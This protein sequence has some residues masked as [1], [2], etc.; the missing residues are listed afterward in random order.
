MDANTDIEAEVDH[1][2]LIAQGFL[3][4][5]KQL[6]IILLQDSVI[7]RHEFPTHPLW[8]DPIF[9]R[10]D[11][12]VFAK[13]VEFSLLEVEEPEEVWIRKTLPAIAEQLNILHQGFSHD[14]NE[15]G[16]KTKEQLDSI[17]AKLGDL[18]EGHISMT[19]SST[20]IAT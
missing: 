3:W 9:E 19:L 4:L 11:Y 15:W 16:T 14:V 10:D 17:D 5:L 13:D 6:C 20:R 2:D 8:A 1:Q 18:F 12:R 7:M